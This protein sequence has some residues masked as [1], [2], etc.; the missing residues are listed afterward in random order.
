M[1]SFGIRFIQITSFAAGLSAMSTLALA[2]TGH[3]HGA[4][5]GEPAKASAATRTV[6]V[7][8]GDIFY[9]PKTIQVQAGE[10]VRFVLKNTG[11]LLHDFTIGTA[12]MQAEHQ[13]EM[14]AMMERDRTSKRLT[15]RH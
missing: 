14:L 1:I 12:E 4:G 13:K 10:T 15:S 7:E 11:Q 9:E 5:I 3:S 6:Q 2:D 8:L